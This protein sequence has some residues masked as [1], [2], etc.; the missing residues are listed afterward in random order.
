MTRYIVVGSGVSGLTALGT[1]RTL[2][3][4]AEIILV[5][6]DPFGFYSRPGL[7]YYL[8][9]EIPEKQLYIYSKKDWQELNVRSITAHAIRL[10]P[11]EHRLDLASFGT[12]T[13]DRLLIATGS[14]AVRLKSP[15]ADLEGVVKLDD[16]KDARNILS[17][18]RRAKAAVVIGGGII[19]VE[20]V[21]GLLAQGLKVHYFLRGDRY[22]S[23]VLDEKESRFIEHRLTEHGVTIHFN[24]EDDEF[25]GKRGR[26]YAVR[27][28]RGEIIRCDLV[29]VGIGVR[30]RMELA[31]SAG[32]TTDRGILT[33]EYLQTSAEDVFASG[34]VAQ[35]RDPLTGIASLD[36]LWYPA[37]QQGR[38]AALNM[39]GQRTV[40]RLPAAINVLRLAGVMTTII[41]AVGS[42]EDDDLVS[43]ARGSSETWRQLPN[44]IAAESSTEVSHLRLMIGERTLVGAVVMGDQKLSLPLQ[45]MI[46]VQTDISPIRAWL[47]QPRAP[48]G[49]VVMDFWLNSKG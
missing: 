41:G 17:L 43:V 10:V 6:E 15:G 30:P 4:A 24:T 1:L 18:A 19:A 32:L 22:W 44:T 25:L 28:K 23:N 12:L 36:T 16:F 49:E 35:V 14:S 9:N 26:V 40:Y 27:T 48:L 39:A 21:E 8:T 29:A 45:E 42:G 11:S 20:L 38:F 46:S 2:D 33:D 7:A 47:L 34:D 13:Y 37:R 5:G 31:Q 3:Q